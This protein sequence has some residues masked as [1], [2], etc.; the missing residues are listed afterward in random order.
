MSRLSSQRG[1][2]LVELLLVSS[3]FLVVLS[4]TL[5]T[6][7]SFERNNRDTRRVED[8]VERTRRA[9][10]RGARQLRNLAGRSEA[11][12][13][14]IHR[15]E[16]HDF[17]FQTADPQRTWVRHCTQLQ[18]GGK[19]VLWS[20]ANPS[21]TVPTVAACPGL[22]TDWPTQSR[23]VD[24]VTNRTGGR[25]EPMFTYGRTCLPGSPASCATALSSITSVDIQVLIDDDAT[26]KPSEVR[27]STGV[28]LRNQN[29]RPVAKFTVAPSAGLPRTVLLNAS[30]SQDPEG[31]TLSYY[32]FR[33]DNYEAFACGTT[34]KD[35]TVL[36]MGVTLNYTFPSA[37][38]PAN[39]TNS[40]NIT[41]VVCD[42]GDLSASYQQDVVIPT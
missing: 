22:V 38:G 30:E 36:G 8:Q 10:E 33:T 37:A 21:G 7:T 16:P 14:T 24:N 27:V 13:T 39:G 40:K 20:L 18:P 26:K 9:I 32:W 15:A 1:F 12:P 2:S 3:L 28:Y 4:A 6:M 11:G 5:T 29:E 23:V 34:P 42:P 35:G 17:V 25:D 19:A 41:L 31:R